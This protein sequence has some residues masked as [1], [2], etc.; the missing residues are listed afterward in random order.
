[1]LAQSTG[2]DALVEAVEYFRVY[3]QVL[4]DAGAIDFADMV[5]LVVKGDEL[6]RIVSS[7][8]HERL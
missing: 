7:L 2:V 5:P 8:D 4:R 6:K 1:M 3:Q